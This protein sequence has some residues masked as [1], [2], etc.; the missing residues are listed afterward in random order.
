MTRKTPK[1]PLPADYKGA[2]PRQVA[3]PL[4][5]YRPGKEPRKPH[6]EPASP[7]AEGFDGS[8]FPM[9]PVRWTPSM[10]APSLF[11]GSG[12]TSMFVLIGAGVQV[13]HS[14]PPGCATALAGQF[15]GQSGQP[16]T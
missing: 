1:P 16:S 2:T 8:D 6:R 9:G 3:E 12:A 14:A 11:Q 5:R 4:L 7:K 13:A 10:T 15:E